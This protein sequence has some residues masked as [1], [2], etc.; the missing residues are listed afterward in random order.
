MGVL[1]GG[2]YGSHLLSPQVWAPQLYNWQWQNYF[3]LGLSLCR[4]CAKLAATVTD[5]KTLRQWSPQRTLSPLHSPIM[6][7]FPWSSKDD[8]GNTDIG[9]S[10]VNGRP[11]PQ[12]TRLNEWST[13][14]RELWCFYLY[15]VVRFFFFISFCVL[16]FPFSI[17]DQRETTDSPD[18]NSVRLN[19]RIFSISPAMIRAS[20]RSLNHAAAEPT[21]CCPSWDASAIVRL[22]SRVPLAALLINERLVFLIIYFAY[23]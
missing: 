22:S 20:R 17:V 4:G 8:H 23:A 16:H 14:R 18:S 7:R 12:A 11:S 2:N 9:D 5:K 21:A 19:S 13:S 3:S 6:T 15:F 1:G 10:N